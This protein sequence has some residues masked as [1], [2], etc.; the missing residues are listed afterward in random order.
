MQL[1]N[2]SQYAIRI[3]NFL[4]NNGN[5][6]LFS[7]KELSEILNIP[8]KFLTK[9]MTDLVK[10]DFV[11]SI[12]GRD[13]GF[14]LARESSQINLMEVLNAFNQFTE[15]DECL[16]GIGKCDLTNKCSL[17]DQWEKPKSMI[18][19]MFENTTLENLEGDG[20]KI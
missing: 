1:H 3:L 15:R 5:S 14:K 13:G 12:R 2:T 8:Y 16:L 19:S 4:A 7:A 9:I 18:E 17:H 11:I 20:F 10:A 6:K